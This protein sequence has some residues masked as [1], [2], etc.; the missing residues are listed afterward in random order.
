MNTRQKSICIFSFTE[1]GS[2]WNR[3]LCK[4]MRQEGH[5]C[6]GYTVRRYAGEGVSPLPDDVRAFIG[7]SWGRMDLIFIGAAGIAVRLIAAWV[8]DKYTDPAVLVLDEKGEYVIPLLSGH[9]GGAVELADRVA[10]WIKAT[11]VHTTATDVQRRFAVD[12]FARKNDLVITDREA[13]KSVSAAVLEGETA[14]IYAP[15]C[16]LRKKRVGEVSGADCQDAYRHRRQ[17]GDIPRASVIPEQHGDSRGA[18]SAEASLPAGALWCTSKRE[19][20]TYRCRVLVQDVLDDG[21]EREEGV[22]RLLIRRKTIL[23][24]V[25]CR[26][27]LDPELFEQ[28]ILQVLEK[29]QMHPGQVGAIA[30]IDLKKEE[31]AILRLAQKW[32]IPFFT[33]SADQLNEVSQVSSVS[34]FVKRTTGTDNVCERA[35]RRLCLEMCGTEGMLIQEKTAGDGMTAALVRMPVRLN[36]E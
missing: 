36:A 5:S 29:N 12:V 15:G 28:G 22:L 32:D 3:Y 23:L 13:A 2:V 11:S 33:F 30:S 1:A 17:S 18:D 16:V 31:Q 9:V 21:E 34:E 20:E 8:K 6:S 25:G 10:A 26:K 14:A 27:A 4:R 7:E 35:A 19:W 24:G